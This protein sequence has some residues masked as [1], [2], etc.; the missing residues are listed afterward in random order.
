[1]SALVMSSP[2]Y[3]QSEDCSISAPVHAQALLQARQKVDKHSTKLLEEGSKSASSTNPSG[4]AAPLDEEG[5]SAV[6]DRCCQAE[7][8]QFINRQVLNL[9]LEVCDE[10]GL[11]GI[12]PHHSCEKGPQTFAALTSNLL[13]DSEERCRWLAPA[14][15]CGVKPADCPDYSGVPP[16]ADCGCS[17][18]EAAD[19]DFSLATVAHSNLGGVGPDTGVA[20]L[21]YSNAGTTNDG[22]PFD[23]VVTTLGIYQADFTSGDNKNGVSGQFGK[24]TLACNDPPSTEA[25]PAEFM[26]SFVQ[27][28]TNT[29]TTLS[30][31][32]MAIFDLDGDLSTGVETASSKGYKGY[33]TDANPSVVASRLPDGRTKFSSAGLVKRI[34]NPTTP[35]ALTTEQR[36]NSVEYIYGDVSSFVIGFGIESCKYGRNLFFAGKSALSDRCG[37]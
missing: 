35:E 1:M 11:T 13:A 27:P 28:G 8:R 33:V 30:E 34:P 2:Q 9:N 7:M 18:S 21:R 24:I 32:H 37:A 23:I 31:V 3:D 22:A 25:G 15:T 17:R 19:I 10:D 16:S 29:P 12:V 36:Q 26:F 14:G 5:Y 4:A 6:A 20:E